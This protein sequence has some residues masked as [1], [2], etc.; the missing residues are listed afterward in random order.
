MKVL[1]VEDSAVMR[2]LL[3][4]SLAALG[5]EVV[6]A[7]NGAEAWREFQKS[8]FSLALTD[9]IMP[10]V[11]GL[12][13]IRRIRACNLPDYTYLI[14]LTARGEK[15]ALVEAM[16]AGADDFLAKPFDPG[17]L[18]VRVKQGER[19]IHLQ[20]LLAEQNLK[21]RQTQA[22]LVQSEKLAGLG[23]LAAGMAHEINNPLAFVCN[24]LTVLERDVEDLLQIL[25]RRRAGSAAVEQAQPELAREI[26]ELERQCD[27]EWIKE[28]LP[29]LFAKSRDGLARV[30]KIVSNLRDF[31]HLDL[32]EVDT[33]DLN[34]ALDATAEILGAALAETQLS[35]V[36][37]FAEMP[38]ILCHAGKIQQ[39]LYNLL[40]NAIQA[41]HPGGAIVLR[42]AC[43]DQG[44]QVEIEDHGLGIA[45]ADLPRI[46]EP[47]FTTR[48]V[49]QGAGLGLAIAY[50][51][52]NDHGGSIAVE[53]RSGH[54]SV[55]RVRLPWRGTP[56]TAA[57]ALSAQ[58]DGPV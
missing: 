51:I 4:R 1:I 15:G 18:R 22:A 40:L 57:S 39:L 37:E 38:A 17:E 46:F 29:Q 21:L 13:L 25:E 56:T 8:P 54:G 45:E 9:W 16:E 27:L 49:G 23:Q 41:S 53:S 34:V 44:V 6:E 35:L 12:E 19:M 58:P 7:T 30:R 47:F 26:A 2:R 3:S 32:A 52:V 42:T 28:N 50:G 20:R 24:N 10:E 11:D 33:L 36:R 55:F 14:L 31:A 43:D 5:F 48:P